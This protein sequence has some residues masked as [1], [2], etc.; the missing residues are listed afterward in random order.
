MGS[1][2]ISQ[3]ANHIEK[4]LTALKILGNLKIKS[5]KFHLSKVDLNLY[6]KM[7]FD[8]G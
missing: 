4:I 1:L 8:F 2:F 3:S 6:K 5:E 7:K